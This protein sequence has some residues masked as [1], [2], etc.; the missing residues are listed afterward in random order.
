VTLAE[1]HAFGSAYAETQ[2]AWEQAEMH[3][4]R[5]VQCY[6]LLQSVF[7]AP[8]V[9]AGRLEQAQERLARV[10]I[11]T[12]DWRSAAQTGQQWLRERVALGLPLRAAGLE[13]VEWALRGAA[14]ERAAELLAWLEV[15]APPEAGGDLGA[16]RALLAGLQAQP[17]AAGRA[18]ERAKEWYA[19]HPR[20]SSDLP[21]LPQVQAALESGARPHLPEPDRPMEPRRPERK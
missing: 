7:A 21:W 20:V 15:Q 14:W 16:L 8:G 17:E 10:Q 19:A 12:R 9:Y 13:V 2:A 6:A 3:V 1:A 18:W 5:A 11:A 4:R